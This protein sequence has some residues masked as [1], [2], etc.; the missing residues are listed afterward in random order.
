MAFTI[1]VMCEMSRR[2]LHVN[3]SLST[4][5]QFSF[6]KGDCFNCIFVENFQFACVGIVVLVVEN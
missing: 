5:K 4:T 1:M 3:F 6:G 2:R